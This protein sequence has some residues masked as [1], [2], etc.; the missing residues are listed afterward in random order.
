MLFQLMNGTSMASPHVCGAVAI[1]LSGLKSR[2]LKWTPFSVK[3][4]L[5][6]TAKPV[7]NMCPYGQGN[8][9]L[10]INDAF[11]HLVKYRCVCS[12]HESILV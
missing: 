3:R 1:L 8:G 7:P 12:T 4:A 10:Q 2:S 6:A 9:L 11:A 5:A